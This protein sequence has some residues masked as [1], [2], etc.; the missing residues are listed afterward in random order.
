MDQKVSGTVVEEHST[1]RSY[2]DVLCGTVHRNRHLIPMDG[3][4][5]SGDTH[6]EPHLP[7]R[8]HTSLTPQTPCVGTQEKVFRTRSGRPDFIVISI[9]IISSYLMHLQL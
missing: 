6:G 1:P 3:A 9:P 5:N 8:T 7:V 2:V 4:E